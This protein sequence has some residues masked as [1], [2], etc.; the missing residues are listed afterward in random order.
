[1]YCYLTT[2]YHSVRRNNMN[3]KTAKVGFL[4]AGNMA[5]AIAGGLV[6]KEIVLSANIAASDISDDALKAFEQATRGG[7]GV[8]SNVDLV[9]QSDI[10]VFAVKPYHAGDV[11]A[12]IKDAVSKDKLIVTICAGLTTESYEKKLGEGIRVVRVMPNTP[13]LVGLGSTAIAG[14]KYATPEDVKT[15]ELMFKA[16]GVTISV[17]EDK[18]D[19]VTGFTGSGPAYFFY[20]A[21][22]MIEAAVS[23]GLDMEQATTMATQLMYG[24]GK[25]AMD[26]PLSL[27]QLR[28]NVTTP[29][30]TTEAGLKQFEEGDMKE[31]VFNCIK[32][33]TDRSTELSKLN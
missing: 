30:G 4:G 5:R 17:T 31:L 25:L 19:L 18:L 26:S 29:N 15:V 6:D 8:S 24:A 2:Y 33:A 28:R 11:C 7:M 9:K 22:A 20:F 21:E 14:G 32:A 27:S 13:A 10:I 16:V 23:M 3:I 1:M 12:A